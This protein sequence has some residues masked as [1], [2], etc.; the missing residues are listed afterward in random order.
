[1]VVKFVLKY[2]VTITALTVALFPPALLSRKIL[3][4]LL[5]ICIALQSSYYTALVLYRQYLKSYEDLSVYSISV[6]ISSFWIAVMNSVTSIQLIRNTSTMS[7][8]IQS[9]LHYYNDE[10]THFAKSTIRIVAL[11]TVE[12][13][14]IFFCKYFLNGSPVSYVTRSFI[15]LM[16]MFVLIWEAKTRLKDLNNDLKESGKEKEVL[17]IR[18]RHNQ[19]CNMIIHI[20]KLY[21]LVVLLAVMSCTIEI[22]HIAFS[23]LSPYAVYVKQHPGLRHYILYVTFIVS[24]YFNAGGFKSS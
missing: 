21:G 5:K 14:V 13:L 9:I 24:T 18:R 2:T 15:T 3:K 23:M 12:C 4:T 11:A 22:C 10:N 19:T 7:G 6:W 16:C 1:M 17:E 20:N 8:L